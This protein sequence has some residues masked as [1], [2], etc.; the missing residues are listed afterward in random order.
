MNASLVSSTLNYETKNEKKEGVILWH[1]N[2][3]K[4]QHSERPACSPK[5]GRERRK[6]FPSS[7]RTLERDGRKVTVY[8]RT[9]TLT[10]EDLNRLEGEKS[11]MKKENGFYDMSKMIIRKSEDSLIWYEAEK[12]GYGAKWKVTEHIV[13]GFSTHKKEQIPQ[14][15]NDPQDVNRKIRLAL[16]GKGNDYSSGRRRKSRQ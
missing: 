10:K 13:K 15:N 14:C 7:R 2:S 9:A 1:T 5:T 16:G 8:I 11:Y 6:S 3:K 4:A 12:L